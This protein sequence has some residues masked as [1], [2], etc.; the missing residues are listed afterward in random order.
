[1]IAD[2]LGAPHHP[3]NPINPLYRFSMSTNVAASPLAL[4]NVFTNYVFNSAFTNMSHLLDGVV[5][6]RVR[7]FDNNGYWMTSTTNLVTTNRN[8]LFLPSAFG[9]TG[10]N[11]FSN[12]LPGS[13]EIEMATLEDRTLQRA[14][15]IPIS[16]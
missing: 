10:F 3:V 11:M 4:Y 9:E 2:S 14:G 6:L 15:S 13:V 7:A 5:G 1:M 12:T 8:V 16:S